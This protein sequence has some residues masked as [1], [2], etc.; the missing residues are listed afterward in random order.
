MGLIIGLGHRQ[1]MGKDTMARFISSVIRDKSRGISVESRSFANKLK[2]IAYSL[3]AWTGLQQAEY[4][5]LEP[6]LK[7]II[8]PKIGKSPRQ[9]WIELGN[10]LR[11]YDPDIWI[12]PVLQNHCP[13]ILLI[14]DL[15]YPNEARKI[16]EL[17]GIL[18][19]CH[20]PD[21]PL[22]NDEADIAL[23]NWSDWNYVAESTD[24]NKAHEHAKQIVIRFCKEYLKEW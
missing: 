9:L 6:T 11:R 8:L 22:S 20:R 7:N 1:N 12:N 13:N 15:R 3:Y 10:Y 23:A 24:L 4:Y 14:R 16:M 18:I 5:E 19:K 17:D 21:I 2:E